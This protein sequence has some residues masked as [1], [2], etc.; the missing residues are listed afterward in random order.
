M[1]EDHLVTRKCSILIALYIT[2]IGLTIL[3]GF[4]CTAKENADGSKEIIVQ[5]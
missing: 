3:P 5:G 1:K 4:S 2:L